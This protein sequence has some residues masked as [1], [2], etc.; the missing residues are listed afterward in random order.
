MGSTS[1]T[2]VCTKDYKFK[3][4]RCEF[5]R[6]CSKECQV[7]DWP[8][9]KKVCI[10]H[11]DKSFEGMAILKKIISV[12]LTRYGQFLSDKQ[13]VKYAILFNK[14]TCR[15]VEKDKDEVSLD[16]ERGKLR[17]LACIY[18]DE[19]WIP[20]GNDLGNQVRFFI[21]PN[22]QPDGVQEVSCNMLVKGK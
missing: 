16:I 18:C 1:Y 22:G 15:L 21:Y 14:T 20:F 10:K 7:K 17:G 19:S 13:T 12:V 4:S 5:A 2:C 9:H 3:C 11:S 8:E 6:Y